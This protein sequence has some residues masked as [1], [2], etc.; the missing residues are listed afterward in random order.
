M[1]EDPGIGSGGKGI[2]QTP[3]GNAVT[4]NN[5]VRGSENAPLAKTFDYGN[6]VA[7]FEDVTYSEK[8]QGIIQGPGTATGD[9]KR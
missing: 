6:A 1:K 3:F 4:G 5:P 8:G 7:G 9:Q 2:F